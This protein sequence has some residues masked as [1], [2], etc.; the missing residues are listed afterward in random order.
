V[1]PRY[2]ALLAA[3]SLAASS[4]AGDGGAEPADVTSST[5]SASVVPGPSP[6]ESSSAA[7]PNPSPSASSTPAEAAR[8]V[9]TSCTRVLHIGESTSIGLVS[10]YDLPRRADRLPA[11]LRRVGVRHVATD[12]S[13]ARSIVERWHDQPNAEEA[14][15]AAKARGFHGCWEIAMGTNEAANQAA[16]SVVGSRDRIDILMHAIG[17]HEPVLWLTTKTRIR[18]GSYYNDVN[19]RGFNQ[20]LFAACRRY[21]NLRVFN[22]RRETKDSWFSSDGIHYTSL[23]YRQRA[24][25]IAH[26]LAAAYPRGAA[27]STRCVVGSGVPED[28]GLPRL[29]RKHRSEPAGRG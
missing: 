6:A 1:S 9:R 4:C 12:I 27:P 16:G 28:W 5:A 14:V 8:P 10:P 2:G 13:G 18:S 17:R 20:A 29:H 23:G 24:H 19:M 11:Q 7:S 21:P 15:E 25:R 26:A 22:W 3:L